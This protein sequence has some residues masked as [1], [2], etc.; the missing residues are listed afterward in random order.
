MKIMIDE[1]KS[2]LS[3][4]GEKMPLKTKQ[5]KLKITNKTSDNKIINEKMPKN[6][7]L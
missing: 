7:N 5:Q 4:Y 1:L 2:V 6:I 3:H